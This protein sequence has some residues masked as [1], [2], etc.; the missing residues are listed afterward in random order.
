[1]LLLEPCDNDITRLEPSNMLAD[2][3]NSSS[4]IRAGNDIGLD[5]RKVLS[6][7]DNE[8]AILSPLLVKSEET[9]RYRSAH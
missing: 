4:S 5:A 9:K 2:G 6:L 1:M 3:Q 8:V 7:G